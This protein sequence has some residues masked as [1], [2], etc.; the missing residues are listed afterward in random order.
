MDIWS[1]WLCG[2]FAL[3]KTVDHIT[4]TQCTGL[5][6]SQTGAHEMFYRFRSTTA[7]V[8]SSTQIGIGPTRFMSTIFRSKSELA[9]SIKFYRKKV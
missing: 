9:L 6:Q 8:I 3:D 4:D 2:Q 5:N 7:F 1:Y